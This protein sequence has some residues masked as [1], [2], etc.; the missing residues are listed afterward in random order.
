[1]LALTRKKGES[2]VIGDDI[3]IT[4][5]STSGDSVKLGI[6]APRHIPVNRQE[7]YEQ[8]KEQNK[9]AAATSAAAAALAKLVKK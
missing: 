9:Q 6:L 1:M 8:I 2:I 5:L 7:I 3:T 4:I